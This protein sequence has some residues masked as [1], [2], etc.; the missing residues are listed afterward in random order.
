MQGV[1]WYP[2]DLADRKVG[3]FKDVLSV[4]LF[5]AYAFK[6]KGKTH[7]MAS[8]M[9]TG[10]RLGMQL[11]DQALL[12]LVASGDLDPNEAYLKATDKKE[13]IFYVTRPE[14]LTMIDPGPTQAAAGGA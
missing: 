3:S 8:T 14:L 4:E 5:S 12:T 13:F 7:Q 1:V 6:T 2:V 11:M 10:R 9:T